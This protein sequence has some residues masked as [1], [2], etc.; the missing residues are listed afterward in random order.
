MSDVELSNMV[1]SYAHLM[2]HISTGFGRNL[3]EAII[4]NVIINAEERKDRG[5]TVYGVEVVV[6]PPKTLFA[7]VEHCIENMSRTE[8]KTILLRRNDC[9]QIVNN[10]KSPN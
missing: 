6:V 5:A 4:K 9:N 2:E 8:L 1:I 10:Q 3:G 7:F